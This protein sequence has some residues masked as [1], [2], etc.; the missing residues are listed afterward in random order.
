MVEK[1]GLHVELLGRGSRSSLPTTG[2]VTPLILELEV[3]QVCLT[4]PS[5]ILLDCACL[6]LTKRSIEQPLGLV[7][8]VNVWQTL[9][10]KVGFSLPS[11]RHRRWPRS[12]CPG[13]CF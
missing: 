6:L 8:T 3:N 5:V 9:K 10:L 4:Y 12:E 2:E 13:P 1:E 11:Q 7:D